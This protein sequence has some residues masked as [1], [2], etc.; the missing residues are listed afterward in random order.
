MSKYVTFTPEERERASKTN[1]VELLQ[2]RGEQLIRQGKEYTWK[3]EGRSISIKDNLWFDQYERKGGEAIGFV[4]Y[5]FGYSF[6]DAV[7][8]LLNQDYMPQEDARQLLLPKANDT[9]RRVNAYLIDERGITPEI[10][11]ALIEKGM[12]YESCKY[13]NAVF[14]GF[15]PEGTPR[16]ASQRSTGKDSALKINAKGSHPDYSFHWSGTDDSIYLF[17]SPIDMLSYISMFPEHWREHS[18]AASCSVSGSVLLRCLRDNPKLKRVFL[19]FD[20]DEPGQKA[21]KRLVDTLFTMGYDAEI[22]VPLNKD[23]NEDLLWRREAK[24]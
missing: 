9:M 15:D 23:W 1:L 20:N 12:I 4:K 2:G 6:V 21:A 14:V 16:H 5:F 24:E 8:F 17:E 7:R 11:Y 19:C 10:L 3:H 13:H 18:Y 22:L